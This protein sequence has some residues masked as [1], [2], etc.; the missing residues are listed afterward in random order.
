MSYRL[1]NSGEF[2][3][4]TLSSKTKENRRACVGPTSV[5]PSHD[6]P[7]FWRVF[8]RLHMYATLLNF[9]LSIVLLCLDLVTPFPFVYLGFFSSSLCDLRLVDTVPRECVVVFSLLLCSPPEGL[10]VERLS[11][12]QCSSRPLGPRTSPK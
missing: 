10:T 6:P 3:C 7:L 1:R 8:Q 12:F 5:D 2:A 11:P 9:L 4:Y